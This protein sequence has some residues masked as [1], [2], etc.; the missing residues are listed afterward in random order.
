MLYPY[1]HSGCQVN[2]IFPSLAVALARSLA[3]DD[4][5]IYSEAASDIVN[6]YKDQLQLACSAAGVG[7]LPREE[8]CRVLSQLD[9]STVSF[10]EEEDVADSASSACTHHSGCDN[11]ARSSMEASVLL[12]QLRLH[13]EENVSHLDDKLSTT[14]SDN[15]FGFGH[16]LSSLIDASIS[17]SAKDPSLGEFL[18]HLMQVMCQSKG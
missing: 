8:V 11:F 2:Q 18:R 3:G 15:L 4:T 13:F 17:E 6:A 7:I 14:S 16:I 5:T 9:V 1:Q 12:S 10:M